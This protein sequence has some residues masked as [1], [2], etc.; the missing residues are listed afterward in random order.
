MTELLTPQWLP[1]L[2]I[3]AL[4]PLALGACGSSR[5]PAVT[6]AGSAGGGSS[7]AAVG[8]IRRFGQ[9][10]RFG[11]RAPDTQARSLR[12]L[13]NGY[14]ASRA[15]AKY[16]RACSYLA[17]PLRS[18]RF[19]HARAEHLHNPSCAATL[20]A[21]AAK[22]WA[23]QRTEVVGVNLGEVRVRGT[24]AYLLYRN[25]RQAALLRRE[26]AHWR[27]LAERVLPRPAEAGR[28]SISHR[29]TRPAGATHR[30][31]TPTT[32]LRLKSLSPGL[33]AERK[34]EGSTP[35]NPTTLSWE[36]EDTTQTQER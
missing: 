33:I 27:V 12:A 11:H 1:A 14:L 21:T 17:K 29:P 25:F 18:L 6:S 16:A 10:R 22:L 5:S 8:A 30:S 20:R 19:R 15:A 31:S 24:S 13:F 23:S 3:L 36:R 7:A 32:D 34:G 2:L 26:G 9:I 28:T 4:T 35:S